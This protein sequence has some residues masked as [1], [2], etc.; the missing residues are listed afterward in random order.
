MRYNT[1]KSSDEPDLWDSLKEAAKTTGATAYIFQLVPKTLEPY[2]R[3][4]KVSGRYPTSKVMQVDGVTAYHMVTGEPD[5][6]RQLLRTL[7]YISANLVKNN[8][9][10]S[11]TVRTAF[12]Q[13]EQEIERMINRS[14]P[15]H[16]ALV[17]P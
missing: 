6:L 4:W 1:I 10:D 2:H 17:A 11:E 15:S 9:G 3:Q 16:S 13:Q 7:P 5:A 12:A 8:G 14:L